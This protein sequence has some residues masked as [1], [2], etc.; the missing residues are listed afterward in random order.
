MH[1]GVILSVDN[2]FGIKRKKYK[3]LCRKCGDLF[4]NDN[5]ELECMTNLN[6]I[7]RFPF[8][9]STSLHNNKSVCRQH[10]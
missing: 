2:F 9:K 7:Q 5:H 4:R 3:E 10:T 8:K 6:A 1:F